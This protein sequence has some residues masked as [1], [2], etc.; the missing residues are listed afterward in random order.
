VKIP[1]VFAVTTRSVL[2]RVGNVSDKRCR[3]SKKTQFVFNDFFPENP[4]VCEV[5]WKNKVEPG[6]QQIPIWRV[7]FACWITK[8]AK[9]PRIYTTYCFSASSTVRRTGLSI[10]CIRTQSSF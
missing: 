2:L 8:A 6:R 9:T 4:A 1:R 3:E 5:M 10:T 7:R